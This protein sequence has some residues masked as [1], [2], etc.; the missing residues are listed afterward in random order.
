MIGITMVLIQVAGEDLLIS[1]IIFSVYVWLYSYSSRNLSITHR[2]ALIMIK[3]I[4]V[5][6][7][8]IFIVVSSLPYESTMSLR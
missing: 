4:E 5:R 2:M 8:N 6:K 7:L 3:T 1:D